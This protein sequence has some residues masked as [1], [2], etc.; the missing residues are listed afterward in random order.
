M[1]QITITR[2]GEVTH[3]PIDKSDEEYQ[4]YIAYHL[5]NRS[6]GVPEHTIQVEVTP[7]QPATYD[8][9]GNELT[10]E[11]PPTYE[12]QVVASEFECDVVDVTSQKEQ[13]AINAAALKYL[14]ETDWIVI[15]ASERGEELSSEFKAQREAAR[16]S[17]VR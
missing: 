17:I 5:E 12:D 8:E 11:V 3:G 13:E 15:R 9:E 6:W 16:V 1:K 10:P 14:E 7:Y 4:E 2:N